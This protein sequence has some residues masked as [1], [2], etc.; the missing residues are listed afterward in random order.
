MTVI[1]MLPG[2]YF[3]K[4]QA[5][6]DSL[7]FH[8]IFRFWFWL[9]KVTNNE[10]ITNSLIVFFIIFHFLLACLALQTENIVQKIIQPIFVFGNFVNQN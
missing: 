9:T 8:P 2:L 6:I 1:Q 10:N 5:I 4:T 7:A 3:F